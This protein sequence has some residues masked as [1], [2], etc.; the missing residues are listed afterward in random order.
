[1]PDTVRYMLSDLAAGLRHK[2]FYVS[3]NGKKTRVLG[4]VGLGHT[5][6]DV[7]EMDC[8]PGDIAVFDVQPMYVPESIPRKYI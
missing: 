4:R 7:T 2:R 6:V 3:V 8:S 1:M 5:T